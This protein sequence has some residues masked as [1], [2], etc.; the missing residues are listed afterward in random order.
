MP[1]RTQRLREALAALLP[2]GGL[3]VTVGSSGINRHDIAV[4]TV[5]PLIDRDLP[6]LMEAA[7]AFGQRRTPMAALS[8]G[9]AGYAGETLVLTLPGSSSGASES[10]AAL[11]PSLVQIFKVNRNAAADGEVP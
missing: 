5:R 10:L 3:L 4:D 2:R 8:R 6:G 1:E 11:L 9:I 7:R